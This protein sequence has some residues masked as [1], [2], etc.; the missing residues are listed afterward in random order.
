MVFLEEV[1]YLKH[2]STLP[3]RKS[4]N[5]LW[6]PHPLVAHSPAQRIGHRKLFDYYN[7]GTSKYSQCCPP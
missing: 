4:T 1:I 5:L 3:Q 6:E 7:L 2:M